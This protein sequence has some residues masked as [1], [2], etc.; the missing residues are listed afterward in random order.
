[1]E[2]YMTTQSKTYINATMDSYMMHVQKEI[3]VFRNIKLF[4]FH[5]VNIWQMPA[6][7]KHENFAGKNTCE[8]EDL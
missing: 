7:I 5:K 6:N 8:S 2:T 3:N 1:M 4:S